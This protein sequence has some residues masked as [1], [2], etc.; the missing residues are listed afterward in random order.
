MKI[1]AFQLL[2]FQSVLSTLQFINVGLSSVLPRT[3]VSA[4]IQLLVAGIVAGLQFFVQQAGNQIDPNNKK[5]G[6]NETIDSN[7]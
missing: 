4:M 1:T 2:I 3:Q 7:K 6:L 5:E